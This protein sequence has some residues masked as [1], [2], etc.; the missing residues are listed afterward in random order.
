MKT[1]DS[2]L[3]FSIDTRLMMSYIIYV[4]G[5]NNMF[6]VGQKVFYAKQQFVSRG[7]VSY[8]KYVATVAKVSPK[9]VVLQSQPGVTFRVSKNNLQTWVAK[10]NQLQ[11]IKGV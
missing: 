5:G 4:D 7:Y 10:F 2:F 8:G 9:S 1:Q 3:A 6:T 11:S